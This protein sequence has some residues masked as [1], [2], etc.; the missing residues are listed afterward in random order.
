LKGILESILERMRIENPRL[1]KGN[2]KMREVDKFI[3]T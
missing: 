1:R 3:S 2:D